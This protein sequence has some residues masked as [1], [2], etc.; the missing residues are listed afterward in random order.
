MNT[1]N[2]S[3]YITVWPF[4]K[5]LSLTTMIIICLLTIPLVKPS[6]RQLRTIRGDLT[7]KTT[8]AM[9]TPETKSLAS[10]MMKTKIWMMKIMSRSEVLNNKLTFKMSSSPSL[11]TQTLSTSRTYWR[12]MSRKRL[13]RSIESLK[14]GRVRIYNY[15][16]WQRRTRKRG[17]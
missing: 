5:I 1:K 11:V 2:K 7:A 14:L 10:L 6:L 15:C 17:T 3:S 16:R 12:R 9:I 13:E 8:A 4:N